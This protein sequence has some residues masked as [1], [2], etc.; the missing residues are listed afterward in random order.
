[1]TPEQ[2][3]HELQI[4]T[5]NATEFEAVAKELAEERMSEIKPV[6]ETILKLIKK[7]K[8]EI[9]IASISKSIL[10]KYEEQ[11]WTHED[12]DALKTYLETGIFNCALTKDEKI[13][14]ARRKLEAAVRFGAE[15]ETFKAFLARLKILAKPITKHDN[16]ASANMCVK[17][18]FNRNISPKNRLFYIEQGYR[19]KSPSEIA[20]FLDSREKH[21][22]QT[23][24]NSIEQGSASDNSASVS[25]HPTATTEI[26]RL[27]DKIIA[28]EMKTEEKFDAILKLL[29]S[30]NGS[31][32]QINKVSTGPRSGPVN[33]QT[34]TSNTQ[35]H[36]RT[37]MVNHSANQRH[38]GQRQRCMQCGLIGHTRNDC[39]RTCNA[40]CHKCGRRGHL[41]AVCRSSKNYY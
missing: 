27:Q 30:T 25:Q 38:Q 19:G 37:P 14:L 39:P 29:A 17:D 4:I 41:K 23:E 8:K 12:F 3:A 6:S 32:A 34:P 22:T 31:T 33:T 2:A 7:G 13:A 18:A 11:I 16:E 24:I 40:I 21:R 36:Q 20:L 5:E 35:A 1:M 10:D 15:N 9:L 26:S 28:M